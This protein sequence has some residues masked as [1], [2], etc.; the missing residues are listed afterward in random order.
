MVETQGDGGG[1]NGGSRTAH[2][3]SDARALGRDGRRTQEPSGVT[4][5]GRES[6]C[7]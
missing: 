4:V 5:A 1:G 6:R 2:A 7:T 3:S